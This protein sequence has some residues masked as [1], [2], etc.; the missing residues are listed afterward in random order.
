MKILM[1]CCGYFSHG[2]DTP[3][4]GEGRWAMN[5]ARFLSEAGHEVYACT[6]G[7]PVL[8]QGRPSPAK[9]VYL[10]EARSRAPYDMYFDC[11][12]TKGKAPMAEARKY[13]HA[14]WGVEHRHL[15]ADYFEDN[16]YV[17]YILH[18]MEWV[19]TNKDIN[20]NI[21]KTFF[22]PAP[23][24]KTMPEP[25]F[26]NKRLL[27]NTRI[28]HPRG[29]PG[30][31]HY[32][33]HYHYAQV[34]LEVL[35][36][37]LTMYPDL[38][39]DSLRE[40]EQADLKFPAVTFYKSLPYHKT[41][42]LIRQIKL[43]L[44]IREQC[45]M[46]DCVAAGVPFLIWEDTTLPGQCFVDTA[47]KHGVLIEKGASKERVR[48]IILTLLTNREVYTAYTK[49]L[50]H[51]FRHYTEGAVLKYFQHIVDNVF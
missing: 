5:M 46:F 32:Q 43:A 50:Q 47:R 1:N 7:P 42:E 31:Y 24:C 29:F 22:L 8:G 17:V 9:L 12:W 27:W 40:G 25:A 36:E 4:K 3:V 18:S 37:V 10:D 44:P 30:Q 33:Q 16:H 48:E 20:G 34:V 23:Y 13:F 15:D 28:V 26:D 19:F 2:L 45:S 38:S 35:G 49:D 21:D 14:T 51:L 11:C 6:G 41:V 39:L